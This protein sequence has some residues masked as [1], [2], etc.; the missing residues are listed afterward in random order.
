MTLAIGL[1]RVSSLDQQRKGYSLPEQERACR[2]RAEQ[3]GVTEF[4]W[5]QEAVPGE[6][7]ETPGLTEARKLVRS[8]RPAYFI[9]MDPDRFSRETVKA[10]M[11]ANEIEAAGTQLV[12]IQ[13]NYENTA[14][15]RL[16][17]TMRVAFAEYEKAKIKE[18]TTRGRRGKLRRGGF[19][20][21]VEP[22]GYQWN[23]ERCQP[24]PAHDQAAI[25]REMFRWVVTEQLGATAIATRLNERGVPAPAGLWWYKNTVGSILRNPVYKGEL[26]VMRSD[27]TEM[28]KNR[29]LP[30]EKRVSRRRRPEA[31]WVTLPVEPLVD[32]A[33][34]DRAQE[35]LGANR[36][37][38]PGAP[39][40]PYLLSGLCVCGLC[41]GTAHGYS[42]RNA[43]GRRF[44]YYV[45]RRR[46]QGRL[47]HPGLHVQRDCTAPHLPAAPIEACVWAQV[48]QAMDDPDTWM[49]AHRRKARQSARAAAAAPR[50]E[51]LAE[52][53]QAGEAELARLRRLYAKG[54][55]ESEAAAEA[56]MEQLKRRIDALHEELMT[57]RRREAAATAEAGTVPLP[58]LLAA[59]R[60]RLD[61][62]TPEERQFL[63]R[64]LVRRVVLTPGQDPDIH[65]V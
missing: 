43:H 63:T 18:R 21:R 62:T 29:F 54:L 34:W 47:Y 51:A 46:K 64:A 7:I 32:P 14:E 61:D 41:G 26:V 1:G 37:R 12:F 57:I 15:G 45:C 53:V 2:Q 24:V 16:F 30:P 23:K 27:Q 38:R 39:L 42:L 40:T 19:P 31:E 10:I 6:I 8:R 5:I 36:R 13:H 65:W 50:L 17:F 48:R 35:I 60:R 44:L 11:I 59:W 49:E 4:V 52:Q 9:C 33:T 28:R 56:E 58:A 22:Y 20:F 55:A 25:V 3:L